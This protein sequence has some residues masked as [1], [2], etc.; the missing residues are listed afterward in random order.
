MEALPGARR[1][2]D[3]GYGLD[4]TGVSL[5]RGMRARLGDDGKWFVEPGGGSVEVRKASP[6]RAGF[7]ESTFGVQQ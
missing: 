3:R 5:R 7:R 4:K 2:Q 6:A 1:Q